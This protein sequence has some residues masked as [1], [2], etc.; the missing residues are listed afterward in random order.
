MMNSLS[1][2]RNISDE[3]SLEVLG[4][5]ISGYIVNLR[6][7]DGEEAVRIPPSISAK[8]KVHQSITK[9]RSGDKGLGCI[10]AHTMCFGK[11]FQLSAIMCIN[12][13]YPSVM[14][15][16]RRAEFFAK[17]RAKG[18]V[19]LIGCTAFRNFSLGKHVKDLAHGQRNLPR[20]A[21]LEN[22]ILHCLNLV[23]GKA[24][25]QTDG[26]LEHSAI[27]QP[28]LSLISF[29]FSEIMEP[30]LSFVLLQVFGNHG[31]KALFDLLQERKGG[32]CY[33]DTGQV[34]I[35][36]AC[37][38]DRLEEALSTLL[39]MLPEMQYFRVLPAPFLKLPLT[40]GHMYADIVSMCLVSP[41]TVSPAL[42]HVHP[43][44]FRPVSSNLT[45][46]EYSAG[47]LPIGSECIPVAARIAFG[48]VCF[49]A[50]RIAFLSRHIPVD[51][52]EWYFEWGY[53]EGHCELRQVQCELG[54]LNVNKASSM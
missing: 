27:M 26:N 13:V 46:F 5:T 1:C 42:F 30:K 9:V 10:L 20:I 32:W 47:R 39:P 14:P 45:Q 29:K 15:P 52:G 22:G 50:A 11:T 41:C 18:G 31:A 48:F 33:V 17:W 49:V 3:A 34:L 4:D 36:S 19:F 8:L 51:I 2:N 38:V 35:E 12:H 7:E 37:S 40:Y 44:L 53:I 43:S 54:K 6:R 24:L 16:V 28:K 25:L 23:Q 21:D